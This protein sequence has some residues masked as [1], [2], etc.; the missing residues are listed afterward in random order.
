MIHFSIGAK[1][2]ANFGQQLRQQCSPSSSLLQSASSQFTME[3]NDTS[4]MTTTV[5]R[6]I[7]SYF[8]RNLSFAVTPPARVAVRTRGIEREREDSLKKML[9][10]I[11]LTILAS[12][13]ADRK[14]LLCV[15]HHY[16]H[17]HVWMCSLAV[18]NGIEL[19]AVGGN[20]AVCS[21][22]SVTLQCT[23]TGD[24][25]TWNTPDGVLNFIQGRLINESDAGPYHG[26]LQELN[27]THLRS[28]LTFTF[29]SQITISCSD[30]SENISITVT[31][32]GIPCVGLICARTFGS[33]MYKTERQ[34][35][36]V[37]R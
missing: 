20:S 29:T 13:S 37:K 3:V 4:K 34:L 14:F 5:D 19:V 32:K 25:L 11:V 28:N 8:L 10:L 23:L 12:F 17:S 22:A 35:N 9:R 26:R 24:V 27:S 18:A 15:S 16:H 1:G 21:G 36:R 31:V 2:L 6:N 33:I 30:G 7:L